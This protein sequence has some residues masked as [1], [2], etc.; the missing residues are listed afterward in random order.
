MGQIVKGFANNSMEKL[1]D[2][3]EEYAKENNL[4]IVIISTYC[5]ENK[6]LEER[7]IVVFMEE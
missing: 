7:A 6:V 1:C 3:I 5:N 2:E 4:N